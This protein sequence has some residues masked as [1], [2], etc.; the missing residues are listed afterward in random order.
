MGKAYDLFLEKLQSSGYRVQHHGRDR[1]RAQCPGH[2]GDDL[3]LSIAVGDQGI[4]TKCHS[5][6]CPAE[7]V[8]K[9]NGLTLADLFDEGGK[10]TYVYDGGHRVTRKRTRDGKQIIQQN[11][12]PVT[13]LYRHPDSAPIEDSPVVVL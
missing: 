2:G 1:A 8:A 12:P 4:L 10:A 9:A 3:N 6:D 11:K 7:D 13:S 5:Y